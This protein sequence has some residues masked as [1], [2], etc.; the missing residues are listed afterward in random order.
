[1]SLFTMLLTQK[2]RAFVLHCVANCPW[3]PEY[4]SL[5]AEALSDVKHYTDS[6]YDAL[7]QV[8]L[9][10]CIYASQN[11]SDWGNSLPCY[12]LEPHADSSIQLHIARAE[13]TDSWSVIHSDS[14]SGEM[15]RLV[16]SLNEE[17]A[18][19]LVR[20]LQEAFYYR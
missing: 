4:D 10:V 7:T 18:Y 12:S 13:G 11:M 17:Q 1:M 19:S 14:D 8:P 15:R 16:H 20:N 6:L 5:H 3:S 2:M 9:Q